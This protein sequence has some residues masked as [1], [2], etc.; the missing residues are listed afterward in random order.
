MKKS[1]V[2]FKQMQRDRIMK[3]KPWEKSTGPQT[4]EGK[5]IS[6]VN[7]RGSSYQLNQLV[8]QYHEIMNIQK[9]LHNTIRL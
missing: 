7:S 9:E 2:E 3:N 1:S 6:S 4:L 8:K 5:R